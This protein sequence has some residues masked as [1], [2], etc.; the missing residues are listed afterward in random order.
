MSSSAPN[1]NIS[2]IL[3]KY[4]DRYLITKR[5]IFLNWAGNKYFIVKYLQLLVSPSNK[6]YLD[7][8]YNIFH[9]FLGYA[10]LSLVITF[11]S[12]FHS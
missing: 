10:Y 7:L 11:I 1:Q 2:V 3:S 12:S 8:G 4:I 5:L 9:K 6:S